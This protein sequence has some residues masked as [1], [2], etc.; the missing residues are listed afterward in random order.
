MPCDTVVIVREVRDTRDL[1]GPVLEG[2]APAR[3]AHPLRDRGPQR[4]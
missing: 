1:A 3:P 4:P 2:G